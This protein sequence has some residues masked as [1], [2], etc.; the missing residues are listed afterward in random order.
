[1]H[2]DNRQLARYLDGALD[3]QERLALR[4]HMLTC[5]DCA[6]RIERLRA[7]SR[8]IIAAAGR[9]PPP[10]VRAAV[11]A[12]IARP[13]PAAWLE[14]TVALAG[15]LVFVLFFSAL[16]GA[17]NGAPLGYTAD[18]L[19]VVD[20]SA[21]VLITLNAADGA[22]QG[23]IP[24][25]ED[26]RR[27]RYDR[28]RDRLYVLHGRA[29]VA[30]AA[31]TLEIAGR[32]EAPQPFGETAGMA[33]DAQRGKLYVPLGDA[34]ITLDSETLAQVASLD[35]GRPIGPLALTADGRTLF[36]LDEQLATLW[37]ID[38]QRNSATNRSLDQPADRRGWLALSSDDQYIYVLLTNSSITNAANEPLPALWR[39]PA[40]GAPMVARAP[41]ER[42]PPPRDMLLL[43]DDRLAIARGDTIR[44]GIEMIATANLSDTARLNPHNDEHHLAAGP[45]GA[46]F[47][48]NFSRGVVTRYNTD[49]Q[50]IAWQTPIANGRPWDAV[51]VAGGWRWP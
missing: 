8:R 43:D 32:W 45:R 15:A 29:I 41:R 47:A 21:G 26:P 51:F 4:A 18:R 5:P 30:I 2:P 38:L 35:L 12:R 24:I 16:I 39:A 48:L 40:N 36:A 9:H 14:R 44:G 1:M 17:R 25:G 33:L 37:T 3:D 50:T 22:I 28:S 23:S 6:A 27:I 49:T 19:F 20:R 42:N 7:D 46:L 31:P 13:S 34:L 10:D 11:R